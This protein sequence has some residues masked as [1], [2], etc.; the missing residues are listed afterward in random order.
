VVEDSKIMKEIHKRRE[1]SYRETKGK[2]KEYI[3]KRIKA[4]SKRM[5]IEMAAMEPDPQLILRG[6]Y[7]IPMRRSMEE[8]HQIRERKEKYKKK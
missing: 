6:R 4:E 1:T 2:S 8:I 3:L 7:P 5:E